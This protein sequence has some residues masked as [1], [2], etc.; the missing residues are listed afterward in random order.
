MPTPLKVGD[1]L[2]VGA[3][4]AIDPDYFVFTVMKNVIKDENEVQ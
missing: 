4:D 3:I 2:G 1:L